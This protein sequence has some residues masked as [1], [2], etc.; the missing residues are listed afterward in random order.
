MRLRLRRFWLGALLLA[1]LVATPAQALLIKF[2][3]ADMA[4]DYGVA[5][6]LRAQA[7]EDE[8]NAKVFAPL[9]M[10]L[11][12]A[13]PTGGTAA[14][15]DMAFEGPGLTVIGGSGFILRW[16][17]DP[18]QSVRI[19]F[20]DLKDDGERT[21]HAYDFLADYVRSTT[22]FSQS[23]NGNVIQFPTGEFDSATGVV[24]TGNSGQFLDL[25]VGGAPTSAVHAITNRF[26][27]SLLEVE[28]VPEPSPWLLLVM[29]ALLAAARSSAL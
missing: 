7:L 23:V 14:V 20:G 10:E 27:T 21:V 29:G 6:N 26:L 2:D 16:L 28:F 13:A 1:P 8:L 3:A 4:A 25:T 11:E 24:P 15:D 9:G 19:R 12:V 17:D 22:D 18:V 5:T